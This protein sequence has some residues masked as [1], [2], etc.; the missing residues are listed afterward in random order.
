MVDSESFTDLEPQL[1][2]EWSARVRMA[3]TPPS[4][5][6]EYL[7]GFLSLCSNQKSLVDIMGD[8]YVDNDQML[9]SAFNVVTE[10]K[11]PTISKV[12]SRASY[13]KTNKNDGPIPD[14]VLMM[15]L[16]YLFPDADEQSVI[17]FFGTFL[18]LNFQ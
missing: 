15:M 5:L 16:Y 18:N 12:M 4:L 3:A 8:T 10:S 17:F 9:S 6:E 7:K 1:A 14:D 13:K 11:I 2:T